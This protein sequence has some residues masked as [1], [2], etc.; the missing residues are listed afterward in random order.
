MIKFKYKTDR[1]FAKF[2]QDQIL[3][4]TG[5]NLLG[6]LP[7]YVIGRA[8]LL[9]HCSMYLIVES[10]LVDKDD[11]ATYSNPIAVV[12][13]NDLDAVRLFKEYVGEDKCA[14]VLSTILDRCDNIKVDPME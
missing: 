8:D 11:D 3:G 7:D 1:S 10:D 6:L 2:M 4:Y 9:R 5:T 13:K 12:A 14:F